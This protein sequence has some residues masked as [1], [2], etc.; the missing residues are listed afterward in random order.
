MIFNLTY[1]EEN[2]YKNTKHALWKW[3][4]NVKLK[5]YNKIKLQAK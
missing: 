2:N 3:E 1:I 4:K 5:S